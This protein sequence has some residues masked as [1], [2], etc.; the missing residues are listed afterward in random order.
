MDVDAVLRL[1]IEQAALEVVVAGSAVRIES[2]EDWG[3]VGE[4]IVRDVAVGIILICRE[5]LDGILVLIIAFEGVG[6]AGSEDIP[7]WKLIE[8][9]VGTDRMGG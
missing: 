1:A 9:D 3:D 5:W 2:A 8:G 7:A 4:V 6:E